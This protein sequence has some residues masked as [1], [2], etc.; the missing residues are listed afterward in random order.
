MARAQRDP[1]R[2]IAWGFVAV[3]V[4]LLLAV[5]LVPAGDDW[6][7]GPVL[8]MLGMLLVVLGLLIVIAASANLGPAASPLPLPRAT[9]ALRTTGLYRYVRHP[10]YSGLFVLAI[11]IAVRSGSGVVALATTALIVWLSMKARWEERHLRDRYPEYAP[12]AAHVPRFVPV[13][14]LSS[15]R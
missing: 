14:R 4:G 9:G 15:S 10:I 7:V 13:P 5:V 6:T 12:Y 1:D 11:G 2:L 3:Q 8:S